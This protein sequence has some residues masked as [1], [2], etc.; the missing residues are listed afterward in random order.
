MWKEKR[1]FQ[2][3]SKVLEATMTGPIVEVTFE[4]QDDVDR[5][6]KMFAYLQDQISNHEPIAIVLNLLGCRQ[7]FDSDVGAIVPAFIHSDAKTRRPC[8]IVAQGKAARSVRSLLDVSQLART[9]RVE[10]FEDRGDALDFLRR[11]V[12]RELYPQS[13]GKGTPGS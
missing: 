13:P 3:G 6:H 9:F 11:Q 8:A 12:F 4:G 10:V 2:A 7:M 5:G 1:K